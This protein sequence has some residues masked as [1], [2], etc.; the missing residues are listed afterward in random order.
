MSGRIVHQANSLASEVRIAGHALG[1]R[2]GSAGP[3]RAGQA[4]AGRI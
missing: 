3:G 2:G 1:G 4:S